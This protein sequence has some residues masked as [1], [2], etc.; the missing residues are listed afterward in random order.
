LGF[1]AAVAAGYPE[2]SAPQEGSRMLADSRVQ[3]MLAKHALDAQASANVRAG[4][5]LTWLLEIASL[6][7]A[8]MFEQ[9]IH[10][11]TGLVTLR[12]KEIT[13]MPLAVRR[14]ISS[15]KVIK[16]NLAA[17]DGHIDTL[18]E[19][20]FWSKTKALELLAQH[21]QLLQQ[22]D[23]DGQITAKQLEKMSDEDLAKTI[24]E[25][26]EK[27]DRHVAARAR[28][29]LALAPKLEA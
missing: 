6:D 8:R 26:K 16:K 15:F 3:E 1:K 10:P 4:D 5:I 7:P 28:A 18:Y 13:E 20:K 2:S 17:G 19:V 14:C 25:A 12:L 21:K 11:T 9:R 24:A 23:T 29:R 22:R 27:W